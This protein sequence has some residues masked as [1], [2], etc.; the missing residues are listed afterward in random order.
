MG[1]QPLPWAAC[2]VLDSPF[3]EEIFPNT[4]STSALEQLEA[5]SSH[6]IA[7]YLE[8]ETDTHLATTSFQVKTY[9]DKLP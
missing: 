4:P 5:A 1:T 6:P 9:F 3:S 7:S 2:P 8:E